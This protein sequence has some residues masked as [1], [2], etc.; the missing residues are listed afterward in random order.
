MEKHDP[1]HQ[2]AESLIN[3]A[4]SQVKQATGEQIH[5][6]EVYTRESPFAALAIATATGYVLRGLPVRAL[7]GL[8]L[9]I[10]LVLVRPFIFI[11]GAVNLYHFLKEQNGPPG[12]EEYTP[13]DKH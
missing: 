4:L 3:S 10:A 7:V 13:G 8:F 12:T 6:A 5:R 9:R 2:S 1:N 11:F